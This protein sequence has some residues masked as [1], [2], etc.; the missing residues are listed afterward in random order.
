MSYKKVSLLSGILLLLLSCNEDELLPPANTNAYISFINAS[1]YLG[2][3]GAAR[4]DVESNG[5]IDTN[6][7]RINYY[8]IFPEPN[9]YIP[10][11]EG[12]CK[13]SFKDSTRKSLVTGSITTRAGD[14]Y[15]AVLADSMDK[16][17]AVIVQDD[18]EAV[19]DKALVRIMHF[20]PDAGEISLYRDTTR[21]QVFGNMRYKQ[22]T[23]Y[24]P[25]TPGANFS[26]I[27]RRNDGTNK[28][29]GRYFVPSLLAGGAY[30]ILL[31]G[32]VEP[33]DGDIANKSTQIVFYRN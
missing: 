24:M 27:L 3:D 7:R 10:F 19:P 1:P 26:F 32:Y 15:T 6:E 22:V 12:N 33:P 29:V 2:N 31:K 17:A 8:Y 30:T 5:Y 11:K 9:K 23:T 28:R 14:Y 13:V 18:Y 4:A 16:Y 21:Q 25:L 20:S